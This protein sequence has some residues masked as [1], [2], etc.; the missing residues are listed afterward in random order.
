M[1]HTARRICMAPANCSHAGNEAEPV[2]K[3]NENKNRGEKPKRFAHK[4]APNDSFEKIVEA[5]NQPLPK[6]LNTGRNRPDVTGR[7]LSENDDCCCDEPRY[8][9]RVRD[10]EPS[11]LNERRR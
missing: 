7:Y 5:F 10:R 4:F 11:D 3:Q 8:Q 9:H 1:E 6:I 2:Y